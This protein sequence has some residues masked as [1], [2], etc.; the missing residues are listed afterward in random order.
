MK[1]CGSFDSLGDENLGFTRFSQFKKSFLQLE[2]SLEDRLFFKVK[3]RFS[4]FSAQGFD[5]CEKGCSTSVEKYNQGLILNLPV[6][7]NLF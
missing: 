7:S 5:V 1:L 4:L 3:R 6:K 2:V